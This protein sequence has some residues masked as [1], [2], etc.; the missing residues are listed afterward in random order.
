MTILR[1][2][3]IVGIIAALCTVHACTEPVANKAVLAPEKTMEARLV[4]SD[5]A[6]VVGRTVDV[7]AQVNATTSEL[8]GSYTARIRYDTTALRYEQEIAIA[9][10]ALRAT[11]AAS[12]LLRFAGAAPKGLSGGRMAGYR[13]LVLRAN[14][15]QSLQ[16]VV[17]EMHTAARTN[18]VSE[19]RAMPNIVGAAP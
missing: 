6:P 11:N 4:L 8:V 5:S 19:L 16:L 2:A 14:A 1:V 10:D 17:D 18:A 13:F 7:F 9:D 12:G 3:S 15:T